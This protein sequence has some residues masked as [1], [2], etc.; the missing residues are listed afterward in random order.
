MSNLV[1]RI[2][3]GI[4]LIGLL[5]G[6]LYYYPIGAVWL[7]ALFG[8]IGAME[9]WK[10]SP[11][12]NA[13]FYIVP[14]AGIMT[15]ILFNGMH[16]PQVFQ[17]GLALVIPAFLAIELFGS[18]ELNWNKAIHRFVPIFWLAI[19]LALFT[20]FISYSDSFF[21]SAAILIGVWTNDTM[22]YVC[23]RTLGKR[24]FAPTISPNKTWEGVVGGLIFAGVAMVFWLP[25]YH[26]A[27]KF[28]LG[29]FIGVGSTIGDLAQSYWKRSVG[30][31]DSGKILV[32][33]GG[34]LD[35]FDGFLFAAPLAI[36]L[37]YIIDLL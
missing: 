2:I 9:Y 37:F 7:F 6:S 1:Q 14:A 36:L 16:K 28:A 10:H 30:I 15:F 27:T 5:L 33:H 19:P 18:K 17:L 22:A 32:G 8:G 31:K 24:K 29:V 13:K 4:L 12:M 34:I 21:I 23:G 35:R 25:D 20:E 11:S 26:P 3:T